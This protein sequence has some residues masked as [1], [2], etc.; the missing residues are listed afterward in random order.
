MV[1][2]KTFLK[3]ISHCI[4]ACHMEDVQLLYISGMYNFF[5]DQNDYTR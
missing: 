1:N 4:Y 3:E 2:D 5:F